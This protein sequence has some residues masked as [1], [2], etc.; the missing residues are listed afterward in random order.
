MRKELGLPDENR[1]KAQRLFDNEVPSDSEYDE[2][3]FDSEEPKV[4]LRVSSNEKKSKG[5]AAAYA[6][7]LLSMRSYTEHG[8]REKLKKREY[9]PY[10]IDGAI[11]YARGFGYIND[12]RLA[13]RG[14]ERC[15]EKLW[16]RKKIF[17][18]LRSKGFSSEVIDGID[19][20]EIDFQEN[21][22]TLAKKYA[23]KGAN[24]DKIFRALA[25]AGYS[26][27]EIRCA[28]NALNWRNT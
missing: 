25:S 5:D 1:K 20:S 9:E 8:L 11:E 21:A 6:M 24:G 17:M 23:A 28:Q 13:Q 14:A 2:A 3:D 16:G 7:K 27:S 4:G 18:Y 19:F 10:E 15:A 12:A 22:C 26:V